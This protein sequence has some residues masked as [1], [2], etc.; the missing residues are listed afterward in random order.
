MD[1]DFVGF[2]HLWCCRGQVPDQIR[3]GMAG[4][5]PAVPIA[6]TIP[7][8]EEELHF[9]LALFELPRIL[10]PGEDSAGP[11]KRNGP[12]QEQHNESKALRQALTR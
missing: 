10:R 2:D 9:G 4:I 1:E 11:G 12:Q 8:G 3:I 7:L 6:Q 5:E